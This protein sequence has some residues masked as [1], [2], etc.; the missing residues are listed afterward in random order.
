MD[1]ANENQDRPCCLALDAFL[2][3]DAVEMERIKLEFPQAAANYIV[4][5]P[6]HAVGRAPTPMRA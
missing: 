5:P 1:Q 6:A 4:L 2:R 3:Q